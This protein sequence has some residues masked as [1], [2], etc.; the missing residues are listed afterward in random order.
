[1]LRYMILAGGLLALPAAAET[2][3]LTIAQ[4]RYAMLL[5]VLDS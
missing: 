1:M 3:S 5:P 2:S 4:D